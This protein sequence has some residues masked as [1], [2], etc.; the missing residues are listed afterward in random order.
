MLELI[1]LNYKGKDFQKSRSCWKLSLSFNPFWKNL[2]LNLM[3]TAVMKDLS[4]SSSL[5]LFVIILLK[6][7]QKDVG[8]SQTLNYMSD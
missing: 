4:S 5:L 3:L 1:N 8:L 7:K 2:G 6:T